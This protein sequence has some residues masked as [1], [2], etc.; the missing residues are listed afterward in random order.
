MLKFGFFLI[1]ILFPFILPNLNQNNEFIFPKDINYAAYQKICKENIYINHEKC[2]TYSKKYEAEISP[3]L[4]STNITSLKE[5]DKEKVSFIYYNLG[6]IYYHGYIMSKDQDIDTGLAYF[7]ISSFFGSPQSKYKLSIILSN[8]IFEQIYNDKKFKTLLKNLDILK[9]VS[10]TEFYIKNFE[11]L[12]N[13]YNSKEIEEIN[14]KKTQNLKEF[15]NNLAMSFLYSATLQN[16]APAKKILA[17]KLN[18]G[19]DVAFSC[20][21][22]LKYYEELS[23]DTLK[24][25]SE[26]NNKLYY[27]YQ[28]IEKFEY[29][30]TKYDE[31]NLKDEK[32]IIELYWSQITDK[33]DSQNLKIIKELAKMYYYGSAGVE[34]NYKT[35]LEL[36]KKAEQLNDTE[37]LY[38]IGEHYLNGWGADQ[39]YSKAYEYFKKSISYNTSETSKSW[40]SLGY[41]Y[42]YGLGV[43]KDIKKAYDYFSIGVTYGDHAA[44][45]DMAYLLIENYK[46]DKKLIE[47]DVSKAYDYVSKLAATDYTFGTYLY[48]MMNQYSLGSTIKS[49]DIN[50]KFFISVCEKNL[51]NKY[52]YDLAFKYYK[53]KM[54]KRAFLLYLELAE[55][56][57]EKA[58]INTALLL[59]NYHIFI[60]K[61]YQKFLTYKFYYMSYLSGNTLASLKMGDFYYKGFGNLPED[62]EKSK[63]YYKE[64]KGA[65]LIADTFKLSNADFNLGMLHLFKENSTNITDD[66]YQSNIYFN[67]SEKLEPLTHYPIKIA[68]LYFKYFYHKKG[69]KISVWKNI[70]YNFFIGKIFNKK[71]FISWQF[72]AVML[73]IFLYGLF[74]IS[75]LNQKE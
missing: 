15:K 11:Y 59:D 6:N 46:K 68:K 60:D 71:L 5:E 33:K 10:K 74:Y 20:T 64:S 17:N 50:I 51:Y 37:S 41:L 49:C 47:K 44:T 75:L 25:I 35:S 57:S 18:K 42:Y 70:L 29:I 53:N 19:Y 3:L 48:A 56:G 69:N 54:Y 73:T 1:S 72:F 34:Q 38:Y 61:D 26:L 32:Q 62:S 16:Y 39:N 23:K 45:Y 63:Q 21:S 8:D 66:I 27:D 28:K 7:I 30:G 24:E 40:N 9:Q 2:F 31:D 52:L 22:A 13:E 55:G 12:M 4:S 58:Q 43:K 14:S 36:F 67:S 65:E